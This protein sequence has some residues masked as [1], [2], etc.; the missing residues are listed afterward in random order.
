MRKFLLALA[1][2]VVMAF[3]SCGNSSTTVEENPPFTG[4]IVPVYFYNTT[5]WDELAQI[6]CNGCLFLVIVNPNNGPGNQTD[7]NYTRFIDELNANG[8]IPIGYVYTKWASR[9]I[10]DVEGDIDTWLKLYPN[11]RGFFIDE[12]S[13][14]EDNLTY[15]KRLVS[16]IREKGNYTVVFNPGTTPAE[17]YFPLADYTVIYE[18]N[19]DNL[20]SFNGSPLPSKSG[21][22]VYGVSS[23]DW[24]SVANSLVGECS[25]LYLTDGNGSNPYDHIPP[26]FGEFVK[27]ELETP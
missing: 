26:Y 14:A 9:N 15:Y 6:D 7:P 4:T 21:C 25:I 12:V 17:G 18:D 27:E 13:T 1:V 23:E 22:I 19:E 5:L 2:S 24:K 10:T 3:Y 11:I 16:Y 8:K 20:G